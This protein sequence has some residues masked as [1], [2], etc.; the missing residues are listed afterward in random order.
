MS[1]QSPH[2]FAQSIVDHY[3]YV[4]FYQY[5]YYTVQGEDLQN[6]AK[7]AG[8][9]AKA[10]T[11]PIVA[12]SQDTGRPCLGR[13]APSRSRYAIS[14]TA[15]P[16]TPMAKNEVPLSRTG[17]PQPWPETFLVSVKIRRSAKM[18]QQLFPGFSHEVIRIQ[19]RS[20]KRKRP[21]R[22]SMQHW[23]TSIRK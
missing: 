6:H 16:T 13:L 21:R 3:R 19:S 9:M 22:H 18:A 17:T 2:V 20:S 11:S 12:S 7:T 1:L 15:M 23:R 8:G 4:R 5:W 10:T 14:A